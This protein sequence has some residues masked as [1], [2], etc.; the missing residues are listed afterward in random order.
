MKM[1]FDEIMIMLYNACYEV[2][3]GDVKGHEETLIQCATQIY[4]AQM[5]KNKTG[6]QI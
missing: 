4:M 1:K 2:F 3:D 5:N 6:E